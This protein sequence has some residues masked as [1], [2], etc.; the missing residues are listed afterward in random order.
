MCLAPCRLPVLPLVLAW[1]VLTGCGGTAAFPASVVVDPF[2][3]TKAPIGARRAAQSARLPLTL[4]IGVD[5]TPHQIGD[6][7]RLT[8]RLSNPTGRPITLY[9]DGEWR[10][11][12]F[13]PAGAAGE[14]KFRDEFP[15]VKFP[16]PD[17]SIGQTDFTLPGGPV[18]QDTHDAKFVV[19][20]AQ[21]SIQ[22]V[23]TIAAKHAGRWKVQSRLSSCQNYLVTGHEPCG[24]RFPPRDEAEA[25]A[26]EKANSE[27]IA[28]M[29]AE[30][31]HWNASA[32]CFQKVDRRAV[33]GETQSDTLVLVVEAR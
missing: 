25:A 1:P 33:L 26:R 23:I 6:T 28:A 29:E 5:K 10:R 7:I 19:I 4:T 9:D 15:H 18:S 22:H 16:L 21:E 13:F 12:R 30:G 8:V 32:R 17:G 24:G 2:T 27:R 20:P 11:P 14:R 31:W 3:D